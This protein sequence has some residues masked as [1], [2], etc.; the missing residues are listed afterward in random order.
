M[1]TPG[2]SNTS[3]S[4]IQANLVRANP[5]KLLVWALSYM[6]PIRTNVVS[7]LRMVTGVSRW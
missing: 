2:M 7:C 3:K 1:V 5:P 4:N 6:S